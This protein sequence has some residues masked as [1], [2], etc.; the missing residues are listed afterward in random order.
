MRIALAPCTELLHVLQCV[1]RVGEPSAR[2]ETV[3]RA[4]L[5]VGALAVVGGLAFA[6]LGPAQASSAVGAAT[7]PNMSLPNSDLTPAHC[8][9][10]YHC[11]RECKRRWYGRKKCRE[12]CHRC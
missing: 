12:V 8:R 4:L 11:H 7:L 3:K 1:V 5:Y 6:M 2:E 9:R 10:Y